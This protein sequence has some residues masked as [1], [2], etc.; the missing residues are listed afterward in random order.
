MTNPKSGHRKHYIPVRK[1]FTEP[2]PTAI[3]VQIV[4]NE[5]TTRIV[6]YNSVSIQKLT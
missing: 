4:C 6:M 2:K 3:V 5:C 1:A